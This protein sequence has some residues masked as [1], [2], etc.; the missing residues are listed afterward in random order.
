MSPRLFSKVLAILLTV[1]LVIPSTLFITPPRAQAF[2]GFGDIVLDPGNLA[3]NVIT[4]I[5]NS[6]S[7][8]YDATTSAALVALQIKAYVLDPLAFVLSGNLLK[9]ITEGTIAFVIGKANGTGI[10]QFAADIQTSL[11]T[12]SDTQAL[13]YFDQYIRN[14]RSPWN[15]AIISQ[16]SKE[17]LN[18]TS[19]AGFWAQNMDTL[20]RTSPNI[21]GYLNGNYRLGGVQSWFALTTQVQNNPYSAYLA[22]QSQLAA[23]IGPGVGG[24]TGARIKDLAHSGGFVS[25]CGEKDDFLGQMSTGIVSGANAAAIDKAGD[26]AYDRAFSAAILQDP[27][28]EA[29]AD[30]LGNIARSNAKVEAFDRAKAANAGNT[31]L[32]VSP[33]DPCTL[34]NGKTGTIKTPGSVIVAGLNKV[35]GGQQD[36]VLR[37]GDVGGQI[38]SILGNVA[39]VLKTVQFAS[40]ILGGPGSGGLLGV[41]TPTS[42]QT[43]SILQAYANS[44]GNLGATNAGVFSDAAKL[45]FSGPEML[46]R[47]AQY[48]TAMNTL[49]GPANTASTSVSSFI[50]YC[51]AQQAIASSTLAISTASSTTQINLVNFIQESDAQIAAA[52]SAFATHV[53]PTIARTDAADS[54]IATARALVQRIQNGLNSST[55]VDAAAYIADLQTLQTMPPSV[56]DLAVAQQDTTITQRAR[57]TAEANPPGSLSI[58]GVYLI[59]KLNLLSA[60]AIALYPVCTAPVAT[61]SFG[62]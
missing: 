17:Y 31:V 28:D 55:E 27:Y 35:L 39:E 51:I 26:D 12:L 15:T 60:N 30:T 10:P 22:S 50:S 49:R 16:L 41:D 4:T 9:A 40:Q 13:S 52:R 33:G 48:E 47:V 56:S 23:L 7:A 54:I 44:P 24:A 1:I 21:G 62:P 45:D 57:A 11:Q 36:N 61:S 59:E 2:L 53:A 42:G 5:K 8:V 19:L 32:G 6:I 25:W 37:M 58:S 34:S 29:G 14:S 46:A 18:K 43:R 20:R 38:T 3:T